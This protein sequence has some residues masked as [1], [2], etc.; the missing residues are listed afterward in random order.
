MKIRIVTSCVEVLTLFRFLTR[1][2]HEYIIYYDSVNAP[3]WVKN[4]VTSLEN[5]KKW[6]KWLEKQW[7]EKIIVPPVYELKLLEEWYQNILPLFEHYLLDNVFKFSLVW[8]I[9]MI[10]EFADVQVAQNL[11]E[12]FSKKYQ[13]S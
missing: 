5:V 8:K 11:F 10:W 4:F 9:G 13:L 6:V 1:Y 2:N 12:N 7:T 3:Y